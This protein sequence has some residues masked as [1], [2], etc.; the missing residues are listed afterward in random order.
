MN[1]HDA[2][3]IGDFSPSLGRIAIDSQMREKLMAGWSPAR[4]L[5]ERQWKLRLFTEESLSA[6]PYLDPTR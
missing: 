6:I 2:E 3:T 1:E 4:G 5:Q